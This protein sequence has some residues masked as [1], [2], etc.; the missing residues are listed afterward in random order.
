[1]LQLPNELNA[2]YAA[3]L[4]QKIMDEFITGDDLSIDISGV[5]QV[6]TVALQVLCVL[7]HHLLQ[8]GKKIKWLGESKEMEKTVQT[9]GLSDYLLKTI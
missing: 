9:L 8:K 2:N 7:Q 6:D 1:M 4:Q 3:T 5:V